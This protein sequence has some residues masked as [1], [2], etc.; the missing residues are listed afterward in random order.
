MNAYPLCPHCGADI[1]LLVTSDSVTVIDAEHSDDGYHLA[2]TRH[3]C[4]APLEPPRPAP[5]VRR[6]GPPPIAVG[7]ARS[8]IR[9]VLAGGPLLSSE[10]FG[11]ALEREFRESTYRKALGQLIRSGEVERDP[12]EEGLVR[13]V[14]RQ[15]P[16]DRSSE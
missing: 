13:I 5:S 15:G 16:G 10:L 9:E 7:R 1:A 14:R 8:F 4:Q 6:T 12:I 2:I 3:I 11:L